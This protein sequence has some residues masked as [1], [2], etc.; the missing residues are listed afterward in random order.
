MVRLVLIQ[1]KF[2]TQISGKRLTVSKSV[3]SQKSS[4][5]F[6]GA[7]RCWL[8]DKTSQLDESDIAIYLR[9]L[10]TENQVLTEVHS[11]IQRPVK[12]AC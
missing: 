1:Y 11:I 3:S 10:M 8:V 7:E 6:W 2:V 9:L 5:R 12:P 4:G